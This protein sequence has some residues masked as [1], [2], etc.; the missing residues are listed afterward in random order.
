[1]SDELYDIRLPDGSLVQWTAQQ[2]VDYEDN[3]QVNLNVRDSNVV[4]D[5]RS[6]W[7]VGSR[8]P[9]VHPL[10]TTH[11]FYSVLQP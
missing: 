5:I 2:S 9:F 8:S 1:M 6:K 10:V 7:R 11:S 3:W 4:E